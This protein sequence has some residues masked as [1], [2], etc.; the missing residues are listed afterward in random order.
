MKYT[1][2]ELP[3]EAIGWLLSILGDESK[4]LT[5]S[6]YADELGKYLTEEVSFTESGTAYFVTHYEE[7]HYIFHSQL[8]SIAVI[9]EGLVTGFPSS[10]IIPKLVQYLIECREVGGHWSN[11]QENAWITFALFRYFRRKTSNPHLLQF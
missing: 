6:K 8:R 5:R 10:S 9:L 7:P 11:T 1:L 2:D 4:Q 3:L